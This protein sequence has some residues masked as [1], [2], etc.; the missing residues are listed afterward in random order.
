MANETPSARS[1]PEAYRWVML[2][3][4]ILAYGTSQF[5]RQNYT[6]VQK[7]IA[8]DLHLDRAAI[9]LLG[10]AFFYSYALFHDRDQNS[11]RASCDQSSRP[12]LEADVS[13]TS[14]TVFEV[15]SS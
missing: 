7:F 12:Y 1:T 4:A 3:F 13:H 5:S 14:E 15:A 6:G 8:A 9:G 10:S 11:A 2:A